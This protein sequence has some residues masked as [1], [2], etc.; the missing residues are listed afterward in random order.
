MLLYLDFSVFWIRVG[1][2]V[3][4]YVKILMCWVLRWTNDDGDG[5]ASTARK[6]FC[7]RFRLGSKNVCTYIIWI[8]SR[9]R[10][11]V[12]PNTMRCRNY[13][14]TLARLLNFAFWQLLL[15]FHVAHYAKNAIFFSFS[16]LD[17]PQQTQNFYSRVSVWVRRIVYANHT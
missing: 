7:M 5:G 12:H 11:F 9:R 17:V 13:T 2:C 3:Y 1:V 10:Y 15:A 4:I 14:Q 6:C 8:F 16:H